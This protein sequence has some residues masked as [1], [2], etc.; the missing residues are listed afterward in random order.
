[1]SYCKVTHSTTYRWDALGFVVRCNN[2]GWEWRIWIFTLS[3]GLVVPRT[4]VK[5]VLEP[6]NTNRTHSISWVNESWIIVMMMMMMRIVWGWCCVRGRKFISSFCVWNFST[7]MIG[8]LLQS[9]D[10]HLYPSSFI[11]ACVWRKDD[12]H[13]TAVLNENTSFLHNYLLKIWGSESSSWSCGACGGGNRVPQRHSKSNQ[14]ASLP[15]LSFNEL[16]IDRLH[17]SLTLILD[18]NIMCVS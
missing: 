18:S 16:E 1:V 7:M 13:S 6:W 4:A 17:H 12:D 5:Q 10:Q 11:F 8:A 9:P 14:S 2:V 15:G 3:R